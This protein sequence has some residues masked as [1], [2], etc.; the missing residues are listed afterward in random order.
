[1]VDIIPIFDATSN[2]SIKGKKN[3]NCQLK[4]KKQEQKFSVTKASIQQNIVNYCMYINILIENK[5]SLEANLLAKVF[6]AD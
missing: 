4:Y 1:M 2:T 3:F 6:G 5:T